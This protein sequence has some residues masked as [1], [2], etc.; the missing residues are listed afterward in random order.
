MTLVLPARP[1]E[2]CAGME[3]PFS[4]A[5]DQAGNRWLGQG[6]ASFTGTLTGQATITGVIP[7]ITLFCFTTTARV[8]T[9]RHGSN[10]R[11]TER[12]N[13][14]ETDLFNNISTFGCLSGDGAGGFWQQQIHMSI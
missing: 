6:T 3:A 14:Y 13:D 11:L 4:I 10:V 12:G 8:P 2:C 5:M 9:T 7:V 1:R